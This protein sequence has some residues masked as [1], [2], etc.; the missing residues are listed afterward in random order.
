MAHGIRSKRPDL[1]SLW[2]F[3]SGMTH[4]E[5]QFLSLFQVGYC[6]CQLSQE[7]CI[8]VNP[9]VAIAMVMKTSVFEFFSGHRS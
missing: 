4:D 8:G 6:L 9:V 1:K 3:S 7:V 2:P 5:S